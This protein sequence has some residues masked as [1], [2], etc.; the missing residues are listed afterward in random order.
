MVYIYVNKCIW[1]HTLMYVQ[2]LWYMRTF[3][4]ALWRPTEFSVCWMHW[5][6]NVLFLIILCTEC[7]VYWTY[8]VLNLLRT[9]CTVYLMNCVL[10]ILRTGCTAY[11]MHICINILASKFVTKCKHIR[12]FHYHY[13]HVFIC[14]FSWY[15][16]FVI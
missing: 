4:Y 3:E 12:L 7:T 6:L 9:E 13:E 8:C 5:E 10:N 1:A 16:Y 2:E 11:W 14:K 15:F